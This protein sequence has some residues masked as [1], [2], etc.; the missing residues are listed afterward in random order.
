[1]KEINEVIE[2]TETIKSEIVLASDVKGMISDIATLPHAEK[3]ARLAALTSYVSAATEKIDV[4]LNQ[5]IYLVGVFLAPANVK[6]ETPTIDANT[7]E[8]K[9]YTKINRAVIKFYASEKEAAEGK[10]NILTVGFASIAAA[11]FFE[12]II[13]PIYGSGDFPA[14]EY[15]PLMVQKTS[16]KSGQTYNFKVIG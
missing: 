13:M 7:G 15:L 10:G 8:I 3:V 2:Q 1:M 9:E 5:T 4:Y 16:C 14:G 11:S 12:N 6:L